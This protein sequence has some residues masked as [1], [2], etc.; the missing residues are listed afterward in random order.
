M[1]D[2]EL[3]RGE[4]MLAL[5][6]L[7]LLDELGT[8]GLGVM[9]RERLHRVIRKFESR[10]NVEDVMTVSKNVSTLLE[11]LTMEIASEVEKYRRSK[12]QYDTSY[13]VPEYEDKG[14]IEKLKKAVKAH[15]SVIALEY[16][17]A[18]LGKLINEIVKPVQLY[19][20]DEFSF[21]IA[22][23]PETGLERLFRL[24]RIKSVNLNP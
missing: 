11:T 8:A 21:L 5:S 13:Y 22:S 6:S 24:S 9:N 15:L 23:N 1:K 3:K 17:D 19:Q 10:M 14:K 4:R 20:R 2:L 7:K 18:S 16:Y 12:V